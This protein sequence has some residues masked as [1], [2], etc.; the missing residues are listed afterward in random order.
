MLSDVTSALGIVNCGA[1]EVLYDNGVITLPSSL[2]SPYAP[3]NR[4]EAVQ[5]LLRAVAEAGSTT[6]AGYLDTAGLGTITNYINRANEM[7]CTTPAS[8]FRPNAA[9]TR[10]EIYKMAAC[11]ANMTSVTGGIPPGA[12]TLPPVFA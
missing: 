10:G 5:I 6:D 9:A 1:I 3:I 8:Y 7:G 11:I 12:L 4:G 2:Y